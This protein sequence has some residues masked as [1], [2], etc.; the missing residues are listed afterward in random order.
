MDQELIFE[1]TATGE[2]AVRERTRVVQRNARMVLVQVDGSVSVGDLIAK[3]GN[4]VLV[5]KALQDLLEGAYIVP[6]A[7]QMLSRNSVKK[8]ATR[9]QLTSEEQMSQFSAFGRSQFPMSKGPISTLSHGPL[10]GLSLGGPTEIRDVPGLGRPSVAPDSEAAPSMVT[11]RRLPAD[12]DARRYR[13]P[14]WGLRIVLASFALVLAS[15]VGMLLYPYSRYQPAIEAALSESLGSPVRVGSVGLGFAPLPV[16]RVRNI[17]ADDAHLSAREITIGKP[18]RLW[19]EGRHLIEAVTID[20]LVVPFEALPRFARLTQS[21][22]RADGPFGATKLAIRNAR[23]AVGSLSFDALQGDL[24]ITPGDFELYLA[25]DDN[26]LTL[27]LTRF[28]GGL[29]VD[30]SALGWKPTN[31]NFPFDALRV[32]GVL[33]DDTLAVDSF[34][35]NLYGGRFN[36]QAKVVVSESG[37]IS[38]EG[39]STVEHLPLNRLPDLG[40]EGDLAAKVAFRFRGADW[41]SLAVEGEGDVR[42]GRGQLHGLDLA[43][44][45]R[46]GRG[47]PVQGGDTTFES[48]RTDVAFTTHTWRLRKLQ[49]AAGL[50]SA[51]GDLSVSGMQADGTMNVSLGRGGMHSSD[52]AVYVSGAVGHMVARSAH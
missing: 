31:A 38:G 5:E 37:A 16:L 23:I 36:G 35:A 43:E 10:S 17:N 25:S 49:V 47:V 6:R 3:I 27:K 21:M 46:R 24:R 19:G 42:V 2:E 15:L 33:R 8:K 1:K 11:E 14:R 9:V 51:N 34:E 22:D 20:G 29:G 48:M 13:K 50:M 7:G 30:F 52:T 44:A 12:W 41:Q 26:R 28:G 45:V 32:K 39:S 4:R 18:W 40:L